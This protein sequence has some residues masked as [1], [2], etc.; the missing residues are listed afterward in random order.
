MA[1]RDSGSIAMHQMPFGAEVQRDRSVAFR[2]YA[3]A[4]DRIR[5]Q[6]E[7]KSETLS[8]IPESSGWHRLSTS[9]ASPGTRY[10]FV[11][12]S[13]LSVP[14]PA[15]RYQPCDV[16][17]PSEVVDPCAFKWRC[18]G[19]KGRA[20][21]EA[22]LY[23]LHVGTFTSEGTFASAMPKLKHLAALGITGIELMCLADFPGNRN[24]GYDG[25][26]LYAPDS[27]YGRPED[28]K[29]FIDAAH[30]NGIMVVLDVV[31]NHFGPEGN[32]LP[33]YFPQVCSPVHT[34]PWG[35][36]FNFDGPGSIEVRE[37][38]IHNALYWIEEFQVDGLRLDASHAMIDE[39]PKHVLDELRDR[40]VATAKGRHVHLILEHE[41]NTSQRLTRD[42]QGVALSYTAQWNHDITHLLAAVLGK[43]CEERQSD[44][45]GETD[46]L[47]RALARGFVIAA[48]E[49]HKKLDDRVPPTAFV[50]FVQTHDL[51]GNRIF[52]DRLNSIVSAD[53][54]RAISAILLLS[55]QVPLLF[56]G[57]EW[58]A[59]T[60]FPF[61]CDYHGDL[62]DAVR[63]GRCDQLT[64]QDPAP[65]REEL[66][67][68]PDP[69]ADSTMRSAQ[70]KWNELE[71]EEHA[72]W[73][74][75][76]QRILRVRAQK[77]I[78]SLAE[79][80]RTCGQ[81]EVLG[82]GVF[83]VVWELGSRR[84]LTLWANLCAT[85]TEMRSSPDGREIWVEGSHQDAKAG[86]WSVRWSIT[87]SRMEHAC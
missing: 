65:S 51:I 70:L 30:S 78:P 39:G 77:I 57:Q 11:L 24:W 2:I 80:T 28:M 38:I 58:G 60:P 79:L 31:Y 66:A 21:E 69:Q 35:R 73:F 86:P 64:K 84:Q 68:A 74:R 43:S 81:Y 37:F 47:C 44:D 23:E 45:G 46:K 32:Y 72:D 82:P 9:E 67:R 25:V 59:S 15:S 42:P 36:A 48:E 49:M 56:M 6:I 3:P 52:G 75:W 61:F 13:G 34:T 26:L 29:A 33:D 85:A 76:H 54:L 16:S 53:A 63:Q 20:W 22:V 7:G 87:D 1:E 40:I 55:P 19:W 12:P 50:A 41:Q 27:A 8:M 5:L 62:A 71:K 17:G 83:R 14:D 18:T 10:V 4:A